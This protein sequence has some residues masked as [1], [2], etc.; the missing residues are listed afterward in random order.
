MRNAQ[1]VVTCRYLDELIAL[2]DEERETRGSARRPEL[3]FSMSVLRDEAYRGGASE[4]TICL[5]RAAE[6]VL[7][8]HEMPAGSHALQ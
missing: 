1:R 7:A 6:V 4:R 3:A 2:L 5:I 8:L